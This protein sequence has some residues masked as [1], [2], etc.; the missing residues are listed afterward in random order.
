[1]ILRNPSVLVVLGNNLRYVREVDE[2]RIRIGDRYFFSSIDEILKYLTNEKC[3]VSL[4][5]YAREA[6][7]LVEGMRSKAAAAGESTHA[8]VASSDVTTLVRT[9]I[10]FESVVFSE[11]ST[12]R[13]AY[14]TPR[15]Y[16]LSLLLDDPST[17]FAGSAFESLPSIA[18]SDI[19]SGC[20]AIAFD[21]PTAAAFHLLRAVERGLQWMHE[22]YFP[23][24]D[25][26]K[27]AWGPLLQDLQHKKRAPR[28]DEVLLEHLDHLRKRFRN[29]TDHPEKIYH[30]GEAQDV[31]NLCIDALNRIGADSRI[32]ERILQRPKA[33]ETPG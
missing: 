11:L 2:E 10:Q 22:A 3:E 23:R 20:R 9:M 30:I 33:T 32:R 25:R 21:L 27:R 12:R 24:G 5:W 17:L 26:D 19:R 6:H 16:E 13:V 1:M 29:P 18:Q 31:L 28:P 15:R 8:A 14:P 4:S 7:D